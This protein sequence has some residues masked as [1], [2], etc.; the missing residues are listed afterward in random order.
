WHLAFPQVFDQGGFDCILGNPPW[1]LMELSEKEFFAQSAPHIAQ[2]ASARQ[3]QI[4]IQTL[5]LDNNLLFVEYVREKRENSGF[6][7]FVQNSAL[8]PT[9]ASGRVNLYPLFVER[10]CS[11]ISPQSRAGL[12]VPSAVSM[13]AYNAPLFM[14]LVNERRLVSLYDFENSGELFSE[15]HR[16]YRIC[17]LTLCGTQVKVKALQFCYFAHSTDVLGDRDRIVT[18]SPDDIELFSPNT[19]APPMLLSSKEGELSRMVYGKF[20]VL[21]NRRSKRLSGQWSA[22]IQRM[23]SL[24][25][26]GDIFRMAREL[27]DDAHS[28]AWTRLYCGKAI[29]Q[30]DHRFSSWKDRWESC[31]STKHTDPNWAIETEYYA[32]TIEVQNRLA[33]KPT[34]SWL[35]S[36]RDVCRATDER[37]VIGAVVP[38]AG[39]DTTCRNIYLSAPPD[40]YALFLANINSFTFD[41]FARQKVIGIHLGAGVFEQLPVLPPATY[42][43]PC[44]WANDPKAES[45]HSPSLRDWLL[46][47]VLELTYTAWDLEAFAADCG[48]SG[49]PF[50][51]D[52]ERRFLLRCELDAAFFHLY[53]VSRDDAEYILGTFDV[54]ERADVRQHG[55]FRTKRVVLERYDALAAAANCGQPYV[56]PLGSPRRAT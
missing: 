29:H 55:E 25:D 16:S 13:D 3:R 19:L 32:R 24:S 10:S 31:E 15:V 11:L 20:G 51:W 5:A 7:H 50:R 35:L 34:K 21:V 27:G 42:A 45:P 9:S 2:A 53:G 17:I 18:L 38:A 14:A 49:P 33:D 47:R 12:I 48:W 44:P 56:S 8:F 46:P 1:E 39:C 36:Y 28:V 41:Y 6:R 22:S 54:L 40:G 4:L 52:E 23:L 30:Y 43:Q 37:T 26:P